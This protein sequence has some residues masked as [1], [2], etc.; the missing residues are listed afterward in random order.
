M[1]ASL[2][3]GQFACWPVYGGQLFRSQLSV[4]VAGSVPSRI[5]TSVNLPK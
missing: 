5:W 3:R 2:L 4:F 1:V